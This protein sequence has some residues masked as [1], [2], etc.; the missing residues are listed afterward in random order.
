[1]LPW[2]QL[3]N[4]AGRDAQLTPFQEHWTNTSG[5]S[6]GSQAST[7]NTGEVLLKDYAF[8]CDSLN[9]FASTTTNGNKILSLKWELERVEDSG[10]TRVEANWTVHNQGTPAALAPDFFSFYL[11]A[12]FYIGRV[13]NGQ[14]RF[15][16]HMLAAAGGGVQS[17][18]VVMHGWYVPA[19]GMLG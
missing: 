2:Q 3:Y 14:R 8:V 17:I 15:Q 7:P 1:M 16:F 13:R 4:L 12:P 6:A 9:I 10:L 5:S 18:G 19:G 11:P